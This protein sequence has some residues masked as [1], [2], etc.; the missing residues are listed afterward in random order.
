VPWV[1]CI[2][3]VGSASSVVPVRIAHTNGVWGEG[4]SELMKPLGKDTLSGEK[5]NRCL[6]GIGH[7]PKG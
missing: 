3:G 6:A 5:T 7:G 4:D 2:G 1:F